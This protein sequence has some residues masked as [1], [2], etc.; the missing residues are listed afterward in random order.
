MKLLYDNPSLKMYYPVLQV[1]EY[2]TKNSAVIKRISPVKVHKMF[3][4]VLS[5][6]SSHLVWL[7]DLCEWL[8]LVWYRLEPDLIRITVTNREGGV[9]YDFAHC[10]PI[11][12]PTLHLLLWPGGGVCSS[13]VI[14][15]FV[16]PLCQFH[17]CPEHLSALLSSAGK[18]LCD[19]LPACQWIMPGP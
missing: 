3:L 18:R 12:V 11:F 7:I 2:W 8:L 9:R 16:H 19:A 1:L 5:I 4:I 17:V 10:A 13:D 15:W 6:I 14:C